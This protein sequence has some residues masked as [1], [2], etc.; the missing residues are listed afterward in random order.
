MRQAITVAWIWHLALPS[1]VLPSNRARQ[2][3]PSGHSQVTC[4]QATGPTKMHSAAQE[5]AHSR[6]T[7]LHTVVRCSR[8]HTVVRCTP[9]HSPPLP[10]PLAWS[11]PRCAPFPRQTGAPDL[12]CTQQRTQRKAP[13]EGANEQYERA[14]FSCRPSSLR[15]P[16]TRPR[17]RHES[18]VDFD[19]R[20]A[21]RLV[22]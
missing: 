6:C 15:S 8:V 1:L 4:G 21:G 9:W 19:H 11:H 12:R 17:P 13:L 10:Q 14:L 22:W 3:P 5:S 18:Y 20:T 16:S 7:L 2:V